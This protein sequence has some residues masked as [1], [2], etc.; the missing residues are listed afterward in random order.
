MLGYLDDLILSLAQ[1][2][3]QALQANASALVVRHSAIAFWAAQ[4][5]PVIRVV[6]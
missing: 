4:R 2:K 5:N 3:T 6:G 1:K